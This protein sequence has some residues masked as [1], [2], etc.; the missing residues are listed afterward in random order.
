M[1]LVNSDTCHSER[2]AK[3]FSEAAEK[4]N[5]EAKIQHQ[6]AECLLEWLEPKTDQLNVLDLGC[7]PGNCFPL[8]QSVWPN[9]H[10]TGI[11]IAEGMLQIANQNFPQASWLHA[12]MQQLPLDDDSFDLIVSSSSMQWLDDVIPAFNESYRLLKS[13]GELWLSL[14]IDGTLSSVKQAWSRLDSQ[15]HINEFK[16]ADDIV[17][18]LT[19]AGFNISFQ[20]QQ[21]L[22]QPF[23]HV[24][25]LLRSI[26][27]IGAHQV[28]R[29]NQGA[30]LTKASLKLLQAHLK[31]LQKGAIVAEY[32][33]LFIHAMKP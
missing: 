27:T 21:L 22:T 4:Y 2:I 6:V 5:S 28:K 9:I 31:Q 32:E 20:Q 25:E 24:L 30:S 16:Q 12:D 33:T 29:D 3:A 7:G 8:V 17:Q 18:Q 1:N 14:Y 11:D 15:Q 26:K 10:Y 23:D 13:G 19:Q